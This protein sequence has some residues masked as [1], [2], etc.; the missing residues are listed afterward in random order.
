MTD[1]K[2]TIGGVIPVFV[3]GCIVVVFG[4]VGVASNVVGSTVDAVNGERAE[5]F[6]EIV[7]GVNSA[8][9]CWR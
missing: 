4:N 6:E 8:G 3:R 9:R 2:G 5:R 1:V 7:V